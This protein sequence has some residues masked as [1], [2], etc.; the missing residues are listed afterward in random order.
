MTCLAIPY[1]NDAMDRLRI[2]MNESRGN[3]HPRPSGNPVLH[4]HRHSGGNDDRG[5]L[6]FR[7]VDCAQADNEK[8]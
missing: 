2:R 4:W 3:L 8:E 1:L 6:R 7:G 5:H